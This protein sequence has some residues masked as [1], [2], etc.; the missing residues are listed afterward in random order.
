MD[1]L[2]VTGNGASV[3]QVLANEVGS[4]G[5]PMAEPSAPSRKPSK[6]STI[7]KDDKLSDQDVLDILE[8]ALDL[9]G[10]RWEPVRFTKTPADRAALILPVPIKVCQYCKHLRLASTFEGGKCGKCAATPEPS[11]S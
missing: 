3:E 2:T 4:G 8:N 9:V 5:A 6:R 10:R 11:P 7:A 1:G